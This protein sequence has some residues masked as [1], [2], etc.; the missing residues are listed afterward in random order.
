MSRSKKDLACPCWPK[1]ECGQAVGAESSPRGL[2]ASRHKPQSHTHEGLNSA[3]T[4]MRLEVDS[5][6]ESPDV[7]PEGQHL[8]FDLVRPR[9]EK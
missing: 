1:K 2:P 4:Q 6:R 9:A 3:V 7:G 5:P 8:G